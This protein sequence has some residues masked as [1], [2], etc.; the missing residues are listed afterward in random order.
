[1]N[2]NKIINGIEIICLY[3]NCFQ[4]LDKNEPTKYKG[5]YTLCEVECIT[6]GSW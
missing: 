1:M 3:D 4:L 6:G 2:T 5:F